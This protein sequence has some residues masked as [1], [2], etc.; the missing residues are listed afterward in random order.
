MEFYHEQLDGQGS[1]MI[2]AKA[3]TTIMVFERKEVWLV[4]FLLT[5]MLQAAEEKDRPAIADWLNA[6]HAS[7][8]T[9]K[10]Q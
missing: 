8:Q 9:P 3:G 5:G 2:D 7:T 6:I 10:F 4:E 1:I